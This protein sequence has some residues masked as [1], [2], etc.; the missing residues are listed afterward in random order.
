M[1]L[2]YVYEG[3]PE[4]FFDFVNTIRIERAVGDNNDPFYWVRD[5]DRIG[6]KSYNTVH[7]WDVH[8]NQ[9]TFVFIKVQ[10]LQY[11][12]ARLIVNIRNVEKKNYS[13]GGSYSEMR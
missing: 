10:S 11:G 6:T 1:K 12:K 3:S 8:R 5:I 7:L 4:G 2:E 9:R 13:N